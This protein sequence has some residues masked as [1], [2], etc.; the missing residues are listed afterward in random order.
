MKT[1]LAQPCNQVVTW[2]TKKKKTRSPQPL[3]PCVGMTW[4]KM[5]APINVLA[6]TRQFYHQETNAS[7]KKHIKQ[8]I[9]AAPV[10]SGT[11]SVQ[12]LF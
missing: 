4:N 5:A 1:R 10:Y 2:L 9:Y 6:F 7:V 12:K 11:T 3:W 8:L